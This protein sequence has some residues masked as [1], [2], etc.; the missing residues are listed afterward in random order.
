VTSAASAPLRCV[1]ATNPV[2]GGQLGRPDGL[3]GSLR[4]WW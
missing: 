4:R 3:G 2:V 1:S